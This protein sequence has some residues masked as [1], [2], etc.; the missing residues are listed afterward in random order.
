MKI[1]WFSDAHSVFNA[2]VCNLSKA[3]YFVYILWEKMKAR[4]DFQEFGHAF[5]KPANDREHRTSRK[6]TWLIDPLDFIKVPN[7]EA[8]ETA[9][10]GAAPKMREHW[11]LSATQEAV[12]RLAGRQHCNC[13]SLCRRHTIRM[14]FKYSS[15]S[16]TN[17]ASTDNDF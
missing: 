1:R 17:Y 15:H 10:V 6:L 8:V 5:E 7:L 11:L 12:L 3:L 4:H 16:C 9:G 13:E 2:P 14:K